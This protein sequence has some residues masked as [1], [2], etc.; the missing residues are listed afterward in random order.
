MFASSIDDRGGI[1]GL[2]TPGFLLFTSFGDTPAR[3]MYAPRGFPSRIYVVHR[4]SVVE[5]D[6]AGNKITRGMILTTSG[7]VGMADNGIELIVVDGV[8]GYILNMNTNTFGQITD[9]DFPNG[10]KTVGYLDGYFI[11]DSPAP[12]EFQL[13]GL[14]NGLSWNGLDFATAESVQDPLVAVHIHLGYL[15]L[16]G[17][18][19]IEQWSSTGALGFPFSR[20]QGVNEE[21]GLAAKE[22][23][24]QVSNSLLF[25]GRNQLG[26]NSLIGLTGATSATELSTADVEHEWQGYNTLLDATAFAYRHEGNSFYQINFTQANKSWLYNLTSD[27]WSELNYQAIN[28]HRAEKA[29]LFVERMILSDFETGDLY[30]L[31]SGLYSDNGAFIQRKIVAPHIYHETYNRLKMSRLRLDLET[32]VGLSDGQGSCP[33][34]GLQVSKD[35][36]HSFGNEVPRSFGKIGNHLQHVEWSRIGGADDYTLSLTMTDPVPFKIL[37][38]HAEIQIGV[39]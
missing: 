11:V 2:P 10:A 20:V 16:F 19:S 9:V 33:H 30:T 18:L 37:G 7:H 4:G 34:V 38:M 13:S 26:K 17:E 31:E 6:N 12:G 25:L 23:I 14:L 24:V 8:N 21:W 22:S 15:I 5:V 39:N 32:G 29:E 36:G 35:G 3:G 27:Q 1:I 28:R